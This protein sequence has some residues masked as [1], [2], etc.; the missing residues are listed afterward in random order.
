MKI[1]INIYKIENKLEKK[2]I[3]ISSLEKKSID[4]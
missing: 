3:N 4:Y 2:Y 1:Y